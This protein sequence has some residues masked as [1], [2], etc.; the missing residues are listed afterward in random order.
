MFC[1]KCGKEN[2]E[3]NEFCLACG[4]PLNHK[5]N[6]TEKS[7]LGL[8]PIPP[9][10]EGKYVPKRFAPEPKRKRHTGIIVVLILIILIA[11][12]IAVGNYFGLGVNGFLK[13]FKLNGT[14]NSSSTLSTTLPAENSSDTSSAFAESSS[15]VGTYAADESTATSKAAATNSTTAAKAESTTS[16]ASDATKAAKTAAKP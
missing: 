4:A 14:Q 15:T 5:K 8:P 9:I 16:A 12:A 6:R 2:S 3:S 1:S 7:E 11:A 13:A 10:F